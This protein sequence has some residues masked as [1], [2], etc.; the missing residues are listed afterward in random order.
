[1]VTSNPD[2]TLFF[3]SRHYEPF[4]AG[5]ALNRAAKLAVNQST[6]GVHVDATTAQAVGGC[7]IFQSL[8]VTDGVGETLSAGSADLISQQQQR[9]SQFLHLEMVRRKE[10]ANLSTIASGT[11][12]SSQCRSTMATKLCE[13]I[14][15]VSEHLS[16]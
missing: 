16:R 7:L 1:M 10:L 14:D 9:H 5:Q 8:G 15:A 12:K 6:P 13:E 4:T 3:D 11:L 2:I